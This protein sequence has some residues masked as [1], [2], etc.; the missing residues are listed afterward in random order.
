MPRKKRT[1]GRH[2]LRQLARIFDARKAELSSGALEGQ[3]LGVFEHGYRLL[4]R[5]V[6]KTINV[7]IE[8]EAAFEVDEQAVHGHAGAHETGR[9]PK[10]LRIHPDRHIRR[11]VLR[12]TRFH[13][14]LI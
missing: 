7:I 13:M 3:F 12:R 2:Q 1:T 14:W 11:I 5:D 10:A 8:A 9:T 4:M 6:G